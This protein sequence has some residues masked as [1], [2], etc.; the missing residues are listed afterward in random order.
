M[1]LALAMQLAPVMVY[2][3]MLDH[4][5]ELADCWRASQGRA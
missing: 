5:V 4:S 3:R 1:P 2:R